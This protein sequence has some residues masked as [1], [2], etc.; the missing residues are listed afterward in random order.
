[1]LCADNDEM[2]FVTVFMGILDPRSGK[3]EYISAGHNPPA[4][5]RADG[6]FTFLRSEPSLAMGVM[7]EVDF[8]VCTTDLSPGDMLFVYSD[9]V[10]EA[11]DRT[12]QLFSETRTI[13]ALNRLKGKSVREVVL[14]MDGAIK[15]FAN[16][17]AP[18]DDITMLA[19]EVIQ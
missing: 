19:V 2:M 17:A 11:M 3:L 6:T 12:G 7:E 9:G 13:A 5:G 10:T 15:A 16:G 4:L 1:M 18:S 14:G 8:A